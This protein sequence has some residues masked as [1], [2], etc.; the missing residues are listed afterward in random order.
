MLQMIGSLEHS[1]KNFIYTKLGNCN[2]L[3]AGNV[4]LNGN[5]KGSLIPWKTDSFKQ[6]LVFFPVDT[7]YVF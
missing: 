7:I 5:P 1:F 3:T 2:W 4:Q 6:E